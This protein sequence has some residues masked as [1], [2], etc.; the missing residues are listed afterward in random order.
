MIVH[1]VDELLIPDFNVKDMTFI[2]GGHFV[3]AAGVCFAFAVRIPFAFTD[4][5][6][7]SENEI[8]CDSVYSDQRKN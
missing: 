4:G 8:L 3:L 1:A 2:A 6:F 7:A 5:R